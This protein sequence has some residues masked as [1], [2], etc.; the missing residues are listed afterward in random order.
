MESV[1]FRYSDFFDND[2][3]FDRVRKEFDQL[4]DDLIKKAKE[5]REKTKLFDVDQAE[6]IKEAEEQAE[7]LADAFKKYGDAKK[8]LN[9]IEE[10]YLKTRKKVNGT[11][12]DQI[13]KLAKLDKQLQT[14]RTDLKELNK[15][16]TKNGKVVEDV[17]KAR[18]EAQINIKKVS[19][20]IRDQ[21]KEILKANELSREEQKLLKA[22][23]TLEKDQIKTLDDVRDRISALRTVVQSLDYEAQADQVRAYNEEI[24]ELTQI[25]SDNS[26]KFIQ[27]KINIGNYEESIVN[28]LKETDLFKTNIGALDGVLQ[29]VL[30]ILFLT[31]EEIEEMEKAS[32]QN[33]NA[34]K[35][36]TIAFGRLNKVLKAS[37][38]GVVLVAIGALASAFGD[39]RAGAV[40]LEKVMM[41]LSSAFSTFGKV[42]TALFTGLGEAFVILFD[43]I[44]NVIEQNKD[45][46]IGQLIKDFFTGDLGIL[47]AV[48]NN[49]KKQ[50]DNIKKTFNEVVELVKSG[51]DAVIQGLDNID[52]AYKLEDNIRRLNQE[53][54]VLNGKLAIAQIRAGDSTKSLTA[55]LLANKQALELTEEIAEKQ[56]FIAKQQLEL[57]NE[58]V[59]QNIKAN[60]VEAK[61]IDLALKGEDFAKATLDLAQQRGVQLEI[62]NDLVEQQQQALLDVIKVE[63]ELQTTREENA[64]ERREINRDIFEQNL[65]L[66]I[67]LIDTEKNL[68]EQYVNDVTKNFQKRVNEFNR[69][70][71]VFRQ[72][73][74][75]E[76]DEFTKEASNLGLDL[77]F[78]IQYDDNGDFDVFVGDT[79][80]A[81]D[82]I[83][84]LNAQLQGLG[85]NEID[86]NRFRE[87]LVETR[88]GIR[89]FR[90]LNKELTL[91]AIKVKELSS[92]VLVSQDELN[93]LDTLQAKIDKLVQAQ[94]VATTTAQRKKIVEQIVE[95]EKQKDAIT[96]FADQQR[97]ENRRDAIDEELKTVEEGSERY[98]ELLNERLAIEKQIKEKQ[99]DDIL[100]STKEANDKAI[101]EYKKF[102]DEVRQV[103]DLVLDK[104]LEVNQKRVDSAKDAVTKQNELTDEQ[105]R[106]AEEGLTNTLAFEQRELGKRE[107][108]L[109]RRQKRQERLEKIKALYSSYNN[110]SSRGDENAIQKA[111]RD[112]ALLKAIEATF[113]EGGLTGID[114]VKT[115]RHGITT[116]KRH[117]RNGRGGNLAWHERGEGFFSRKEVEN[118]GHD[119]FY[120]IKSMAGQGLIDENFFSRQRKEFVNS[121]NMIVTDPGLKDEI[122]EVKRAIEKK[123]VPSWRMEE[124]ANGMMKVVEETMEKN[125]V[126]R[127]H[128]IVKKPRP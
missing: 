38:I 63:N 52:R 115:N 105:R 18:V 111:L 87:F 24:D 121:T 35:R 114:G 23:I 20:E 117:N 2:G 60:G 48:G 59:K 57:A 27:S 94:Q 47:D 14:Y 128:Y 107:A 120:K 37:I 58:K 123:P 42:A 127:N 100:K 88:N 86:I 99:A 39:T 80:L 19:K 72:N 64:K 95:L 122:R 108:E 11:E 104:V 8:D 21:Q 49:F 101:E 98:Y 4:G 116:G 30:G 103:L 17:N 43:T 50:F 119:N 76:L 56:L 6:A 25:L 90:G 82:N 113:K 15:L 81:I 84:E 71:V 45:K 83:V 73:A 125:V 36:M 91:T 89:D 46:G 102:A 34:I 28:A 124:M 12:D 9:K 5:V 40:R 106:R 70:L 16:G 77:D 33:T 61:N 85:I 31:R 51:T 26:D 66:L 93:A 22:K 69:F 74:Q 54:E 75:R 13:K 126:K 112:F 78:S 7:T 1:L 10:E 68:S 32:K 79:K 41:T 67:D 92:N 109:V 65:D 118:M 62:S 44:G 55:Q 96:E 3:G 53:I 110:Y 97:L 29:S